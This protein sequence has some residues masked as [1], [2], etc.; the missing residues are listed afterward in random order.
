MTFLFVPHIIVYLFVVVILLLVFSR[1]AALLGFID[2]PNTRS[3]HKGMVPRVGGIGLFIPYLIL[4]GVSR[5]TQSDIIPFSDAYWMVLTVIIALGT[6]DDRFD[7]RARWKFLVQF[8]LATFY[9]IS[10]GNY[11]DSLYGLFGIH[12]IPQVLGIAGSTVFMVFII[13][14][15]NLIDG[16]D[17]L[18]SGVSILALYLFVECMGGDYYL[19]SLILGLGLIVFLWFNFSSNEKIFLGDAGS[20]GLGAILA[21]RSLEFLSSKNGYAQEIELNP[22]LVALLILGYPLIDALR[23]FIL[24]IYSGVNPFRADKRHIHHDLLNQGLTHLEISLLIPIITIGVILM[25]KYCFLFLNPILAFFV[26]SAIFYL[27]LSHGSM[28]IQLWYR[29]SSWLIWMKKILQTK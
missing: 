6:V 7:I 24:R 16:V 29:G 26:S 13:N 28:H 18:C 1:N 19:T 2:K 21:M 23:V 8:S 25:N 12:E 11:V 17:G 15:V 9:I 20:L 14:A 3:S 27:A 5:L 22:I 10:S 4:G